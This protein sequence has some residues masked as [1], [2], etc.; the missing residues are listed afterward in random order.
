MASWSALAFWLCPVVLGRFGVDV[1]A[2]GSAVRPHDVFLTFL[3]GV[4]VA[5]GAGDA[6]G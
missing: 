5:L 6:V 4:V 2:G 3:S 1:V